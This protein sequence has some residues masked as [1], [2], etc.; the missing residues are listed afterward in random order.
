MGCLAGQRLGLDWKT[1]GHKSTTN[2]QKAG[3]HTKAHYV[4]WTPSFLFL[5]SPH[6]HFQGPFIILYTDVQV[7]VSLQ[8]NDRRSDPRIRP[9]RIPF[10]PPAYDTCRV[11]WTMGLASVSPPVPPVRWRGTEP[12]PHRSPGDGVFPRDVGHSATDPSIRHGERWI[13]GCKIMH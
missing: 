9:P 13:H 2:K 8:D 7:H 5:S 4:C 1:D 6:P 10:I 12:L 11:S 3:T